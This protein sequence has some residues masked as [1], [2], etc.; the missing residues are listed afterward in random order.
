[1]ACSGCA[2]RRAAMR[3]MFAVVFRRPQPPQAQ[4]PR[5][6]PSPTAADY[7]RRQAEKARLKNG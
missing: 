1:M 3:Q 5:R 6:Q 4:Q 2:V 7:A